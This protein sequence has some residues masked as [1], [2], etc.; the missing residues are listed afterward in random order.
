MKRLLT[1][2]LMVLTLGAG[3]QNTE[4]PDMKFRRLDTR[5]GLSNSQINYIFQDS[6]GFVWIGTSYGLNRYDG[7]R[8]RTF[9]SDPSDT[10]TLRNN[11][12]DMVWEDIDGNL[13]VRQGMNYSLF[14]P[15]TEKVIRN[16]SPLLAKIGITGGIDRIHV[17]SK[18][19]LWVKTY[20]NGLYCYNPHTKKKSL[21]KYGYDP[22]TFAYEFWFSSMTDDDGKLIVASSDGDIMAVDGERGKVVWKDSYMKEHGGQS[23]VDYR[24]VLDSQ[25]NI[26][27]LSNG[28]TFIYLPKEKRWYNSLNQ[29]LSDNGIEPLPDNLFIWDMVADQRGWLWLATDHEGLII[30]DTKNKQKKQFLN[31][32]FDQSSLSENTVKRLMLDKAGNMWI[33]A[34]RSGLNQYIEKLSGFSLL[35]LG[36]INTTT[37]DTQG[38]FWLGTDNRGVIKYNPK[39]GET[40]IFDKARCGFAS[41]IIVASHGAKDGSVWFGTYNGGLVHIDKNGNTKNYLPSN[42]EGGLLNNNVWSVTEDKWGRIWIGTLGNGVQMLDPKTGKF[43]TWS[44]YNTALKENF[45]TSLAWINKGWLMAGHG[46]FYSLINPVSGKVINVNIPVIPGKVAAG[47]STICVMEDSRGLVWHGSSAGCCIVDGKTGQQ[48]MLDMNSGLLGSTVVGIVEDLQHT[49]WVVTEHGISNVTPMKEE[50]GEWS[51]VVRTFSSKDGLQQGT[52]NQR[53]VSVTRDGLVL[54]GGVGG[55]DIINPKLMTNA[56]NKERPIFSGLKLFGQQMRVGEEYNGHVILKKALDDSEELVLRYDEN[57]FTIQLGTDK[58]EV[59][60]PSRFVYMLEGFSDKWIKTEESDPNIT[61]MSLKHGSTY[62][63]H[64]RMLNDNGTM[65]EIERTLE[66]TITPPLWRTRWM[67]LLYI[68]GVL[69]VALWWRWRFLRQQKE[70]MELEQLRRETE[71]KHWMSEMK[72]KMS[73]EK[74]SQVFVAGENGVHEATQTVEFERTNI[75]QLFR[76]VCDEFKVPEGKDIRLSFFPFVDVLEVMANKPMLREML[77][78]LL[79][80]SIAFSP[81][82]TKIKVYVE[83]EQGKAL[84]RVA[85]SGV[86]IPDEV[87]SHLFEEIIGD[88]DSPNLHKVFDIVEAHHGTIHAEEN[89]GGGTVFVIQMPCAE[90]VEVEEAVLMD[91]NEG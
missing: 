78:I 17:D 19:N 47:A 75:V 81:S 40:A 72:K 22:E 91:D 79:A 87:K 64:V 39:T 21:T 56:D 65:G 71:K 25:K 13:W 50:N 12:V 5:D 32:K 37:E 30:I 54:V 89:R 62:T 31:N 1:L 46:Q 28:L 73:I 15:V 41:D 27:V 9:Y 35:E 43:K 7:Y 52:Y 82:G 42:A 63:L 68:L 14:N 24:V 80:N 66:I 29:Y 58:G 59:H 10:T 45:M 76:E 6:K 36:D 18:K 38:N 85:D 77:Q 83:K 11:Y 16:P 57:Q 2:L 90:D 53:S 67:M 84:I 26:W 51:F 33:G 69:A 88:D 23:S 55:V 61:Y 4:I 34:Y 3:A 86:G 44:S 20:D 8:F 70:R 74:E 48:T 49:M 60:N